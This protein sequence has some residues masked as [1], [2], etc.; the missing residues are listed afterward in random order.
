MTSVKACKK[1]EMVNAFG[2]HHYFRNCYA[3]FSDE[4][5]AHPYVLS[6]GHCGS[7]ED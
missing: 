5:Q 6:F 2:L 7:E 1:F 3:F 4:A